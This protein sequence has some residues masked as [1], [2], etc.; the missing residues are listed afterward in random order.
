MSIIET[1]EYLTDIISRQACIIHKLSNVVEQLNATTSIDSEVKNI[2]AEVAEL[3]KSGIIN[4]Y[5]ES[6]L[7]SSNDIMAESNNQGLKIIKDLA[8]DI[9][10][11]LIELKK[12]QNIDIKI[13]KSISEKAIEDFVEEMAEHSVGREVFDDTPS[14]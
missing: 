11:L 6:T 5:I 2:Q 10:A 1:V 14:E 8:K 3:D 13:M 7:K 4:G 9:D 12:R